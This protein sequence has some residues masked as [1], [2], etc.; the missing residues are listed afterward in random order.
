MQVFTHKTG[1]KLNVEVK[2]RID[3]GSAPRFESEVLELLGQGE[4]S[5]ILD[6][7]GLDYISSAGLR[8]ILTLAKKI[9]ANAGTLS[10]A[11]L[12][13]MVQEVFTISG[14]NSIFQIQ[15]SAHI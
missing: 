12:R 5:V 6:F 15:N 1:S 9:E 14:L 8:S 11:N 2:G 7:N 4:D 3:A 10:F 13:G